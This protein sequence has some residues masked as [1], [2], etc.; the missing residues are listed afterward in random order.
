MPVSMLPGCAMRKA[1]SVDSPW[2]YCPPC[3]HHTPGITAVDCC[4]GMKGFKQSYQHAVRG[5]E[6]SPWLPLAVL[7]SL[8]RSYFPFKSAMYQ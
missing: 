8:Q 4:I 7:P 5:L 3:R 1:A 6:H 2:L